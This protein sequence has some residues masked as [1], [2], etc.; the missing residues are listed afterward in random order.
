MVPRVGVKRH[1]MLATKIAILIVPVICIPDD[2]NKF[3]E[4]QIPKWEN[5]IQSKNDFGC[6]R[7]RFFQGDNESASGMINSEGDL[8]IGERK[9][10]DG[11]LVVKISNREYNATIQI[12]DGL[13]RLLNIAE[14]SKDYWDHPALMTSFHGNK[15]HAE[16]IRSGQLKLGGY[17]EMDGNYHFSF[18]RND[19]VF[20]STKLVFDGRHS[21]P[22]QLTNRFIKPIGDGQTIW[23]RNFVSTNGFDLPQEIEFE[24]FFAEE[25]SV[26][27]RYVLEYSDEPIDERRCFLEYYGLSKPG[28]QVASTNGKTNYWIYSIIGVLLILVG[29]IFVRRQLG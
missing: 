25:D 19:G 18:P 23:L 24:S 14:S 21:L 13:T 26:F 9:H 28:Y 11:T 5:T 29:A 22:V 10:A 2:G 15:T 27:G 6:M 4:K 12:K 1:N 3:L 16:L 20:E 7:F 8:R 17:Q